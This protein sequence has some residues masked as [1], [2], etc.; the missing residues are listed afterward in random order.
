MVNGGH[1]VTA[2]IVGEVFAPGNDVSVFMSPATLAALDPATAGTGEYRVSLKPG[3]NAGSYTTALTAALG[4][5]YLVGDRGGDRAL[6]AITTLVAMLTLLIIAVAGLG[7]L[8]TVALQ[9]RERAHDIGIFKALGMT[10][11][12]TLTMVV[13]SVAVTGLVA[14]IIAVPAGIALHRDVLPSM[15]HAANSNVPGSV[16][17]GVLA[18]GDDRP[19]PGWPGHRG[20]RRAGAR[21]LG[22]PLAHRH[23]APHRVRGHRVRA[24]QVE[25]RSRVRTGACAARSRP[26]APVSRGPGGPARHLSMITA[27]SA[28]RLA[29][30]PAQSRPFW[31]LPRM[32]GVPAKRRIPV[33]GR[34]C[35]ACGG[36]EAVAWTRSLEDSPW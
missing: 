1:K 11:R 26:M 2:K 12:Q 10:P 4:D 25:P 23:R 7:V 31:I 30:R 14:G 8:N 29:T 33:R 3:V 17:V 6:V 27:R 36:M 18:A 22:G 20:R 24:R 21:L 13:C 16:H 5:G 32:T 15:A 19:G 34:R 35:Y 9:V 28:K